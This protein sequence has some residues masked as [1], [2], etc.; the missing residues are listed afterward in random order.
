MANLRR[1]VDLILLIVANDLANR[2]ALTEVTHI[3]TNLQNNILILTQPV[4][5]ID[6]YNATKCFSIGFRQNIRI[7]TI[8]PAT[9]LLMVAC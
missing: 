1:N 8:E 6:R 5:Y 4:K 9:D 3:I 2:L 7:F